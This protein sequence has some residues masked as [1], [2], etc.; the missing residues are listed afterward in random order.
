MPES[1]IE[2]KNNLE[3]VFDDITEMN[4]L[5]FE[6]FYDHIRQHLDLAFNGQ[7]F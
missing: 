5:N 4:N 3:E 1:N 2:I 7:F 6:G